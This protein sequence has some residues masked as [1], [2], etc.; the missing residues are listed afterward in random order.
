MN[1]QSGRDLIR[2]GFCPHR[3]RAR[4]RDADRKALELTTPHGPYAGSDS[5]AAVR[6]APRAR[7]NSSDTRNKEEQ[8]RA[9]HDM[10]RAVN[11]T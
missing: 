2:P 9:S 3:G 1:D 4:R 5:Q 10:R 8:M 11:A 6:T 7:T